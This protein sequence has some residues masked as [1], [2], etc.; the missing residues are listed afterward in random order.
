MTF[1]PKIKK[2]PGCGNDRVLW[3]KKYGCQSCTAKSKPAK[4]QKHAQFKRSPIKRESAK[5]GVEN[6]EY[7][8][9]RGAYMEDHPV[10]EAQKPGCTHNSS[11]LHHK[12]G[13]IG[14]LLI[15]IKYFMACCNNCHSHIHA[16][17]EESYKVGHLLT[18]ET[19]TQ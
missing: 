7:T 15:N 4:L 18:I 19:Q 14:R 8:R 1:Q 6:R 11:E 13:R 17:P 2:C 16:H 10:C 12:A 3:S 5:R 9:R